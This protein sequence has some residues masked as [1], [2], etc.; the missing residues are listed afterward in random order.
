MKKGAFVLLALV[1]SGCLAPKQAVI[2]D[3]KTSRWGF[4]KPAAGSPEWAGKLNGNFDKVEGLFISA[5]QNI[6]KL[7]QRLAVLE[8]AV[9]KIEE[10]DKRTGNLEE[11]VSEIASVINTHSGISPHLQDYTPKINLEG[12]AVPAPEVSK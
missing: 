4:I 9:P 10:L 5:E 8:K 1:S 7:N 6:G 11:R 12:E 3:A 2:E